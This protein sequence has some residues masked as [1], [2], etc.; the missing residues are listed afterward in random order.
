MNW[1]NTKESHISKGENDFWRRGLRM[2]SVTAA[3][4]T[5][6][7]GFD[8]LRLAGGLW[9][10]DRSPAHIEAAFFQAGEQPGRFAI[11]LS[12]TNKVP[13]GISAAAIRARELVQA[14][15]VSPHDPRMIAL[16]EPIDNDVVSRLGK[17][18][19][20]CEHLGSVSESLSQISKNRES[21]RTAIGIKKK[22]QRGR[23]C[24]L[25]GRGGCVG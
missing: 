16:Q 9:R 12:R 5:E 8:P 13:A 7:D 23:A 17:K 15:L 3:N 2:N 22:D 4:K 10:I 21:L 6:I 25:F 20:F 19:G 1:S 18:A 24:F 11:E 14:G